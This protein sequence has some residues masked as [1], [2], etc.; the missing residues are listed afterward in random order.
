MSEQGTP[1]KSHAPVY[2][3]QSVFSDRM[4]RMDAFGLLVLVGV[5]AFHLASGKRKR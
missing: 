1:V 5:G 2:L 3:Y 4:C